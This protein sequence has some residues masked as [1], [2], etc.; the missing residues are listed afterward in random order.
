MTAAARPLAK[1]TRE[2]LAACEAVSLHYW[3]DHP[4]AGHVWAVD[5]HQRAH[6]VQI[7]CSAS[8]ARHM[9]RAA[10]S[11]EVEQCAGA[12]EAVV[13]TVSAD[14]T[15]ETVPMNKAVSDTHFTPQ[16]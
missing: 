11:D 4:Q 7:S 3:A 1:R 13:Y 15:K 12:A 10:S 8:T 6:V 16:T 5:D 9:C 14:D 2:R